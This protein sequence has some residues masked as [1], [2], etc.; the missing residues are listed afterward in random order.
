ML[1]KNALIAA[2]LFASGCASMVNGRFQNVPVDSFPSGAR[3]TVNCGDAKSDGGTTP[4]TIALQ[5]GADHCSIVLSRDGYDDRSVDFQRERSAMTKANAVP[6]F[7]ASVFG[8]A[9]GTVSDES[10]PNTGYKIGYA[11]GSAPGNAV[12]E[13]TGAAYKLAPNKVFVTLIRAEQPR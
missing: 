10:M 1:M 5:R 13:H 7:I 6:G 9:L 4:T 12:D 8:W 11:L 2:A 3:V